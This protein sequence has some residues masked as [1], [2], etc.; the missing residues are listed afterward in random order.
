MRKLAD[1]VGRV[2]M[3]MYCNAPNDARSLSRLL[4][5]F[6]M[7]AKQDD[8]LELV[9][10]EKHGEQ[11]AVDWDFVNGLDILYLLDPYKDS[12]V[13]ITALANACGVPVWSD[14]IDDLF[15]VRPSNPVWMSY[16]DQKSIRKN[17]ATV[18]RGSA[19]TTTTTETLRQQLP[20]SQDVVVVPES[21]RWP[22]SNLP[23][24]RV[25]TWRGFG[26]HNE[27]LEMVLPQIKELSHLPQFCNWDWVFFGEP[28]W[29]VFDG[30]V[31]KD[32]LVFVPPTGPF[33]LMNRWAG[34]CP[35]V[36]IVPLANNAFNKSKT[37]LAWLEATAV[38]AAVLGPDFPEWDA[39]GIIHYQTPEDFGTKLRRT[40]EEFKEGTF[41][42]A[43]ELSRQEVYPLRTT[44]AVNEVRW[45]I[46][47]KLLNLT[48]AEKA[49]KA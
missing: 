43:L 7:M 37:P 14:Y 12:D 13:R 32:R 19:V 22:M 20:F 28:L 47:N 26:S 4:G 34:M 23:R 16:V 18:M 9:W 6:Q 39:R 29:K 45:E 31:P 1:G 21:C 49:V 8:R 41:H 5:P 46:L 24:Q 2:R 30:I 33:D 11:W 44:V 27:D 15:N 35:W 17:I 38:G 48:G 42:P 10:P 3:G 36:H 40:M 25:V